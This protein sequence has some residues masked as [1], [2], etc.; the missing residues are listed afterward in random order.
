MTRKNHGKQYCST[1]AKSGTAHPVLG[2]VDKF[3][4]TPPA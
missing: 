4:I 1:A 2:L 3:G